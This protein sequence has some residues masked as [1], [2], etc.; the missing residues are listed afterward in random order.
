MRLVFLS[1]FLTLPCFAQDQNFIIV[2]YLP[3]S[4]AE[5]VTNLSIFTVSDFGS[6]SVQVASFLLVTKGWQEA[7]V[8]PS[9]KVSGSLTLGAMAGVQRIDGEDYE[10]RYS[11]WGFTTWKLFDQPGI[12]FAFVEFDH[13]GVDGVFWD[14]RASQQVFVEGLGI[15]LHNRRFVGLGPHASLQLAALRPGGGAVAPELPAS[16]W[17]RGIFSV[18]Y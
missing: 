15:G 14:F 18:V 2:E 16:D 10:L 8:G 13:N 3:Q 4:D 1:L 12:L 6:D 11:P 9:F 7:L 17:G 5:N